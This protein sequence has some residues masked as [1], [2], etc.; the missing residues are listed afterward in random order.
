METKKNLHQRILSMMSAISYIKKD[1]DKKV[2]GVYSFV[3][4]D[5]VAGIVHDLLVENGVLAIPSIKNYCQSELR[6]M[7]KNG[8]RVEG[9]TELL[10][11]VKFINVDDPSDF[12]EMDTV[13]YGVDAADKG[14]G[15]AFSYAV[16]YAYL[17]LLCLETGEKDVDET[18]YEAPEP[19]KEAIETKKNHLPNEKEDDFNAMA[20][21]FAANVDVKEPDFLAEYFRYAK[22]SLK[23]PLVPQIN[24][25]IK[26]PDS[27]LR[28][29]DAWIQKN[30]DT[31]PKLNGAIAA[32]I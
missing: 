27:I 3:S 28:S 26:K 10:I 21:F 17:K 9:R 5:Q 13:G 31:F 18:V 24:L 1:K 25:W 7:T 4:H 16:K 15:K 11:T 2:N 14:P 23:K 30:F 12:F 29:Y 6:V 20:R 19:K 22:K 8:E 32:S